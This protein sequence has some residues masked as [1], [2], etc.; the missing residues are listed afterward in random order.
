MH[1]L[2]RR[3]LTTAGATVGIIALTAGSASAHFCYFNDLND[4]AAAGIGSSSAFATVADLVRL[5]VHPE[6]CDEGIEIIA[7]GGGVTPSTL[8]NIKG[9]MAGGN[10]KQGKTNPAISHLDFDGIEA[11]VPDAFAA[12]GLDLPPME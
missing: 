9:T 1:V 10:V 8:V 12:C 2:L 3:A 4:R 6:M 11:A 5:Y 7:A